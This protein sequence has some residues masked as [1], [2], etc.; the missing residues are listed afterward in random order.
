MMMMMSGFKVV[1]E[2]DPE[3]KRTNLK[4]FDA[5]DFELY[6]IDFSTITEDDIMDKSKGDTIAKLLVVI[7]TSWFAIQCAARVSQ[8]LPVTALE[9][10][11]LGHTVFVV[12]IYFIW[13]H[14]PLDVRSPIILQAKLRKDCGADEVGRDSEEGEVSQG[15][16][17]VGESD[18]NSMESHTLPLMK[19]STVNGPQNP[20]QLSWRIQLGIHVPDGEFESMGTSVKEWVLFTSLL[21]ISSMFGTMHCLGWNSYFPSH[22]EQIFWRVAALTMTAIP[23][24]LLTLAGPLKFSVRKHAGF[25]VYVLPS[26]YICAR[27]SLI[28]LAFLALRDLPPPAYQTPSWINFIPHL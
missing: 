25:V 3:K 15:V 8:G 6:E 18:R 21:V 5:S 7:Q 26:L 1:K 23:V 14:K 24:V 4:D 20:Y 28:T 19:T 2:D 27:I 12:I 10:T 17:D 16:K 11:T 13:W 9:L 22:V